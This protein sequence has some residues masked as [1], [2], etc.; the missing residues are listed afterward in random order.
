M[1]ESKEQA[2]RRK[3]N[4][5]IQIG[6]TT[7]HTDHRDY[8]ISTPLVKFLRSSFWQILYIFTCDNPVNMA[9]FGG[10]FNSLDDAKAYLEKLVP[11]F[12]DSYLVKVIETSDDPKINLADFKKYAEDFLN[13]KFTFPER[14]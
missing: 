9:V 12:C 3:L 10:S 8:H 1:A 4:Q 5:D 2:V 7:I 13:D 6:I 14:W 11:K